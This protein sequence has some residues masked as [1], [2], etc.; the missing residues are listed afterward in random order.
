MDSFF[1]KTDKYVISI[2]N[3]SLWRLTEA[4][5]PVCDSVILSAEISV[6]FLPQL[7]LC[8]HEHLQPVHRW[9]PPLLPLP[10]A[11]LLHYEAIHFKSIVLK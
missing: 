3:K 6:H 10:D 2:C 5:T 11:S 8:E 4:L 1:Q 7:Q 9:A